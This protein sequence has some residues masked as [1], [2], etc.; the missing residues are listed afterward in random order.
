MGQDPKMLVN[1]P[2]NMSQQCA[3]EMRNTISTQGYINRQELQEVIIGL[4]FESCAPCWEYRGPVFGP[5]RH[6]QAGMGTAETPMMVRGLKDGGGR[7]RDSK[8]KQRV[9]QLDK[10]KTHSS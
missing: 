5:E 8:L 7:H 1:S 3:L 2:P 10:R 6:Q 9:V 4:Y